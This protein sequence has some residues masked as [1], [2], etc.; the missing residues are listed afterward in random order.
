[1][2]IMSA[3][4]FSH[5]TR[6]HGARWHVAHSLYLSMYGSRLARR[7]LPYVGSYSAREV[8]LHLDNR[9][10]SKTV[11]W[12]STRRNEKRFTSKDR[13]N[14]PFVSILKQMRDIAAYARENSS[15]AAGGRWGKAKA[16]RHESFDSL[17]T[18]L[19]T[20]ISIERDSC[21]LY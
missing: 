9:Y 14:G 2:L 19:S 17:D 5:A 13:F 4:D 6:N 12:G 1:M 18:Q 21:E 11:E 15:D 10:L 3:I 16:T 20:K 8:S 7:V